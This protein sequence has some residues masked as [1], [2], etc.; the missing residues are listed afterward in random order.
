MI[1]AQA[2]MAGYM[3]H[4][5]IKEGQIFN[6]QNMKQFSKKWMKKVDDKTKEPEKPKEEREAVALSQGSKA[7]HTGSAQKPNDLNVVPKD[8]G[9][10]EVLDVE[11][12]QQTTGNEDVI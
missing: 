7:V 1:K 6:I 3:N 10:P 8:S 11:N 2:I 12:S 4:A 5:R 9:S